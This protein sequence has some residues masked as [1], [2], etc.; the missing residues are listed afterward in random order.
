MYLGVSWC[1]NPVHYKVN[2]FDGTPNGIDGDEHECICLKECI[3][4]HEHSTEQC[5]WIRKRLK[6]FCWFF[7]E[8]PVKCWST[9]QMESR[10]NIVNI[11]T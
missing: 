3:V 1:I 7:L 11:N 2:G 9:Y 5:Y 10:T 4:E 6:P 8:N